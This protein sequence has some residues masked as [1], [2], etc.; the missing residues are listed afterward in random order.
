MRALLIIAA[1]IAA[2][3]T[4]AS[5]GPA[6]DIDGNLAI[7]HDYFRDTPTPVLKVSAPQGDVWVDKDDIGHLVLHTPVNV[8]DETDDIVA[9]CDGTLSFAGAGFPVPD[10]SCPVT[11]AGVL[12]RNPRSVGIA[13]SRAYTTAAQ[14]IAD[15][16]RQHPRPA[17]PQEGA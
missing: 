1:L 14:A 10:V 12:E 6:D 5:A 16:I 11:K 17:T 15:W 2:T 7:I 8:R 4:T 13:W 9:V 3:I